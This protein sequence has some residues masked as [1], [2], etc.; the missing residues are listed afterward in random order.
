MVSCDVVILGGGPVG[1]LLSILLSD[2]GVSNLVIDRDPVPYQLPRAIVMDDEI[3]RLL[4]DHGMGPWIEANT[5]RLEAA[6]F[7][8]PTGERIIGLDIP[9]VGPQGLP[10]TVCHYQPDLDAMLRAEAERR[11]AQVRWGRTAISLSDSTLDSTDAVT[12]TLDNGEVIASRWFVGC[13][14][15]SSW[16]RK[17]LNLSLEDLRFDQE[18]VVVDIQ[19]HPDATVELPVGVR[20]FCDPLRP[21]TF[22][23]GHGRYRRWEFQVQPNEDVALLNS[24]AGL[25]S[26]LAP[27]VT[28]AHATLVR[29]AVYRF[30]AVVAPVMQLGNVFLAGDSAHQMPPF[31]GQGLN[32]G[33]RDAANLA[34]KLAFV[35]REQA[36]TRLLDTYGTERV[37]HVRSVVAHAADVG[38]LIDQLAGRQSHGIDKDAG[39]GGARPAARI[40]AGM[41]TGNDPRVGHPMSHHPHFRGESTFCSGRFAVVTQVPCVLP[42]GLMALDPV[43]T[44]VPEVLGDSFAMVVRPDRY[45]AAVASTETELGEL[46]VR[47]TACL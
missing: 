8:S 24:P 17:S 11:G 42:A 39:Y 19:L 4:H 22:V 32:S 31:L 3:Q 10:P 5:S 23:K 1:S 12:T 9:P 28:P 47:L 16:T 35:A 30:H 40:E 44:V 27:W 6:D 46:A 34:W 45:V 33:M 25:W 29:S 2:M 41:I 37:P 43:H 15:A 18:W 21:A 13:D 20:Q 38:R 14:G 26:L 7:V 36:S